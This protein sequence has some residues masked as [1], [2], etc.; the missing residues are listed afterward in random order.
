MKVVA[1][2]CE[3]RVIIAGNSSHYPEWG[4]VHLPP[5]TTSFA[6]RQTELAHAAEERGLTRSMETIAEKNQI[7]FKG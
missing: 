4:I 1:N 5:Q 7:L 3:V 2:G 6:G